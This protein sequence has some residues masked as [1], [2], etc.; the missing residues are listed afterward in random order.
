MFR[1][2]S[3]TSLSLCFIL[4][5]FGLLWLWTLLKPRL[6]GLAPTIE[7]LVVFLFFFLGG[8]TGLVWFIRKEALQIIPLRGKSAQFLGAI[9]LLSGWGLAVYTIWWSLL[10]R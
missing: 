1:K 7:P 8:C 2:I 4:S 10:K 6:L 3:T 5:S 9:L